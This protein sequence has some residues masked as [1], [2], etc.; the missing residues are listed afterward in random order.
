MNSAVWQPL[1][2]ELPDWLEVI[3]VDLPG[4][5]S[6]VGVDAGDLQEQTQLL[7]AVSQKP[8]L[9]VGWSMGGL[10]V[11]K[12][13]QLYPARVA[14]IFGV[15]STPCFVR[16]A[17]WSTAVA[18][19]V[20]TDFA[21][22]LDNDVE[23]TLRRFLALQVIGD[24]QA[25]K[26]VRNLQRAMHE[27]GQAS[28]QAMRS[29]LNILLES[30]LRRDLSVLECPLHWHLGTRDTLVPVSLADNLKLL[31]PA[32]EISI[33]TGAGHAPFLSHPESFRRELLDFVGKIYPGLV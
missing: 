14:G 31:N 13:A 27:R 12:L 4:H 10:V 25:L 23:A 19:S 3:C 33:E 29:G 28:A 20:F 9:W 30:D 21:D 22:A 2:K 18:A 7:A 17:D 24:A 16:R 26:T 1:I 8:A 6:M 5:G 11:L 32:V 15:A